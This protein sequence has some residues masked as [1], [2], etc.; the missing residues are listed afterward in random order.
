MISFYTKIIS[1]P[2]NYKLIDDAIHFYESELEKGIS[3]IE[4]GGKIET[5]S[6]KLPGQLTYRFYQ[7]QDV[8]AILEHLNIQL[9]QLRGEK[10]KKFFE[11]YNKTLSAREA[12]KYA[13]SDVEV[14]NLSQLINYVALIRNKYTGLIKGFD[15]KSFQINNI[16]KLRTSGFED[17][18]LDQIYIK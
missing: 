7:F 6:S 16:I 14:L 4:Q 9:R 2:D 8:E 11:S 1:D 10:F 15:N 13:D 3:E 5:I 17:A 12:E 18:T